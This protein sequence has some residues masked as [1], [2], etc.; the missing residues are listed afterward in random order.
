MLFFRY[1]S[2]FLF[3]TFGFLQCAEND[4]LQQKVN[5]LEQRLASFTV[6]KLSASSKQ[7]ISEEYSDELKKKV[8]SQVITEIF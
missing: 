5:I 4:E 2:Y 6:D 7:C 3:C 1:E 8:Q